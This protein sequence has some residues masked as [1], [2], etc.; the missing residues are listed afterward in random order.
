MTHLFY[1]RS[2]SGLSEFY[3]ASLPACHGLMTPADLHA[4]AKS[5]ASVLPSVCVKTLGIRN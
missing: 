3:D 2:L 5:G 4:L 1:N